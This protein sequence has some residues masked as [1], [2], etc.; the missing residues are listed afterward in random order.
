MAH[1][2]PAAAR[3]RPA[4]KPAARTPAHTRR[5]AGQGGSGH[6]A[7]PQTKQS[8]NYGNASILA[9][10]SFSRRQGATT[11]PASTGR[12]TTKPCNGRILASFSMKFSPRG[13]AKS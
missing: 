12:A 8:S 10:T 4:H 3:H 7:D 2:K 9:T 11:T 13:E 6:R 1:S 5:T